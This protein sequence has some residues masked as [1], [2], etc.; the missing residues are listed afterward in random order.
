MGF[1]DFGEALEDWVYPVFS[2]PSQ[3]AVRVVERMVTVQDDK[4]N[5]VD[6]VK[7]V[8]E[9]VYLDTQFG[10]TV[11]V[12]DRERILK[13]KEKFELSR[14]ELFSKMLQCTGQDDGPAGTFLHDAT[15]RAYR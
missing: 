7:P 8:L 12:A 1:G 15:S 3:G 2:E 5:D 14:T 13:K 9:R 6:V 4:G 11:F 10:A